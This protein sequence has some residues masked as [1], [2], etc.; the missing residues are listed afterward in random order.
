[1][2][3]QPRRS[4]AVVRA[5]Y[6]RLTE[7]QVETDRRQG[8]ITSIQSQDGKS[9]GEKDAEAARQQQ[10]EAQ[11]PQAQSTDTGLAAA[12]SNAFTGAAAL[13]STVEAAAADD[14]DD[15]AEEDGVADDDDDGGYGEDGDDGVAEAAARGRGRLH[16]YVFA[17]ESVER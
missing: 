17:S 10:R 16:T 1:M 8:Y 14:D 13:L 11:I 9:G 7:E 2:P 5:V 4:V 15:D 3:W 12:S 6:G